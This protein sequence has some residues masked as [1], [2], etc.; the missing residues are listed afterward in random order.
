MAELEA[1]QGSSSHGYWYRQNQS[2]YIACG[3]LVKKR[4]GQEHAVPCRQNISCKSGKKKF[5]KSTTEYE[6]LRVRKITMHV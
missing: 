5:C 2:S 6:Y 1:P 3:Y 4:L